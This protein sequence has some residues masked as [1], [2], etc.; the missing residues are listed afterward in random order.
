LDSFNLNLIA[1]DTAVLLASSIKQAAESACQCRLREALQGL[2]ERET[3]NPE[4]QLDTSC[5]QARGS[6]GRRWQVIPLDLSVNL[7][8]K[9][10]VDREFPVFQLR[11]TLIQA[12]CA[13]QNGSYRW[14]LSKTDC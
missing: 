4:V 7:R 6:I 10:V 9:Y 11:Q 5:T 14:Q 3:A 1:S 13:G 12:K 2:D 8:G